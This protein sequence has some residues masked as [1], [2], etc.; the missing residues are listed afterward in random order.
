MHEKDNVEKI[1][2]RS[3][4]SYVSQWSA[5]NKNSLFFSSYLKKEFKGKCHMVHRILRV[6]K[7]T[8]RNFCAIHSHCHKNQLPVGRKKGEKKGARKY[9][10]G[11]KG[12]WVQFSWWEHI[13]LS[14]ATS[15]LLEGNT[16]FLSNLKHGI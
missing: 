4:S 3:S 16:T 2:I 9:N 14:F 12:F 13:D 8:I 10:Q 6:T 5:S 7:N 15:E 11:E 1:S